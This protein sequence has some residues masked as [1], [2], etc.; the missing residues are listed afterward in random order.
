MYFSILIRVDDE[1]TRI[2]QINHIILLALILYDLSET[3]DFS[4]QAKQ[5][6]FSKY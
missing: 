1:K 4:P 2:Q 3:Q 6:V 5:A